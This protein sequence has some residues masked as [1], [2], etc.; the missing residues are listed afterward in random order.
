M[1]SPSS[2]PSPSPPPAPSPDSSSSSS[3]QRLVPAWLVLSMTT[4]LLFGAW[5]V[6]SKP[7]TERLGPTLTQALS[8][9]GMIPVIG[10]LALAGRRR[11]GEGT[12]P[13]RGAAWAAAAGIVVGL[14]NIPYFRAFAAEGDAVQVV[15][16]TALYPLVTVALALVFLAERPSAFQTAGLAIAAAAIGIFI[17][18]DGGVLH[19]AWWSHALIPLVLWGAGAFLQKLSAMHASSELSTLVFLAAFAPLSAA[20][21]AIAPPVESPSAA[22]WALVLCVGA[23]FAL[24]NL[25]LIAAF[26][27]GGKASVVTPLVGLYPAAAIPLAVVFLGESLRNAE[28]GSIDTRSVLAIGLSLV[29]ALCLAVEKKKG[30]VLE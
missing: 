19:A 25:T 18:R 15:P 24:G 29:A 9:P 22:A 2:L 30:V 16:F 28:T 26:G 11:L 5:A 8:T 17:A 12:S 1:R 3:G 6:L 4:A 27:R 10:I 13:L 21:L 23:T 14:G 20:L 7:A